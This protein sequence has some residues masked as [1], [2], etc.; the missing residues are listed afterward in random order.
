MLYA[1][2]MDMLKK[3]STSPNAIPQAK[4][5]CD[6]ANTMVNIQKNEIQ[7]IQMVNKIK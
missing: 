6:I 5:V 7:L 1:T 4:A 2:P 3:V